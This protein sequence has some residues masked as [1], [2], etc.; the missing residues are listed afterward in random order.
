MTNPILL[1]TGETTWTQRAAHLAAATARETDVYKRQVLAAV[2]S[3][4]SFNFFLVAPYYTLAVNDP[5]ELLDLIIYLAAALMAGRLAAYA[6]DQAA[7]A[8]LNAEQQ[9]IL[10]GLTS[11][12]NPLT[13]PE[14]IRAELR[15]V[16]IERLGADW[17]DFLPGE[18]PTHT[19]RP[20]AARHEEGGSAVF[21]LSLIHI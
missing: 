6:R 4:F 5:R 2:L 12:L 16:V 13:E 10:Y 17:V 9:E 19:R 18:R 14:A 8:G 11:A 7:A 21:V 1:F 15:R 3:F 20:A